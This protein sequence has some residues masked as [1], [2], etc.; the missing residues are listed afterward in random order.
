ML[1]RDKEMTAKIVKSLN[2]K[3]QAR[4]LSHG[5]VRQRV[6]AVMAQWLPLA[7][8]ALGMCGPN[9]CFDIQ[10]VLLCKAVWRN[11]SC[12]CILK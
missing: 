6:Q 9:T 1:P 12:M 5:N 3:I 7:T 8:A 2:L 4:E 11:V 10:D